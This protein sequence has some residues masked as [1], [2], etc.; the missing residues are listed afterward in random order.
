MRFAMSPDLTSPWKEFLEELDSFLS[1]PVEFRCIGG[2]AAVAAY[3]LPRSTNDLDYITL[4]PGNYQAELEES[5]GQGSP[6]AKKYKVFMHRVGVATVP[7]DYAERMAELF[8]GRSKN[9]RLFVLDPYDLVLSKLSRNVERDREDVAF[10]AKTLNLD[11][12]ILKNRYEQEMKDAL[13][14]PPERHDN[15]LK[16]WIEAYFTKTEMHSTKEA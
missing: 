10:L 1:E 5:A 14:G 6:L 13:I 12:A 16:F 8:P 7:A 11:A 4:V 9:I 2:F 3:G 15:T